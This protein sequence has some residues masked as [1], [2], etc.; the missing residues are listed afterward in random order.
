M[1]LLPDPSLHV[2]ALACRRGARLLFKELSFDVAAG[3]VL[4][5]RGRNGRGKTT[6]LRAASG[7]ARPECGR[8]AHTGPLLYVG[9]ANALKDDLT[10]GE[11]LAFVLRLHGRTHD[12]ASADA[13]LQ[14]LGV[15]TRRDAFI[16]TL[17][18]G[19]RRRVALA[20]LAVE[21]VASVWVLDE[22]FDALDADG[23]E[24][25]NG[26]IDEHQR[27]GGCVLLSSHQGLDRQ[28]LQVCEVDLDAYA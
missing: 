1:M 9:H 12:A 25:V 3:Q 7:L 22:P 27:R 4:W 2:S 5:V 24:R 8:I 11:A 23:L 10:V 21:C 18:Q 26:L 17:S 6:L 16:R 13:A 28:H 20:R 15:Q 19:Q 14:R